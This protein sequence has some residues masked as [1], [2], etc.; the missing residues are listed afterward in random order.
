MG[1]KKLDERN[2]RK[3]HKSSGGKSISVTLPIE[4]IRNL[5]WRAKQKVVIEQKGKTI[6]IKDW[7]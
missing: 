7:E 1:R 5:K 3:L 2:I 6:M 4:I